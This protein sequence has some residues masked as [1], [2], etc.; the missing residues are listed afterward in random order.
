MC[1][2]RSFPH[3]EADEL[4]ASAHVLVDVWSPGFG[5]MEPPQELNRG[6]QEH[7]HTRAAQRVTGQNVT[8]HPTHLQVTQR[9]LQA[10]TVSVFQ[11]KKYN[12]TTVFLELPDSSHATE[13]VSDERP[14]ERS[15]AIETITY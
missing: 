2:L 3:D 6:L 1:V 12:E 10:E 11:E 7:G 4:Q 14:E 8:G 9:H 15:V 13:Q 5:V